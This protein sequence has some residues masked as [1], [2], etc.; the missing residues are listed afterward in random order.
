[1]GLKSICVV[2]HP[3]L[4][5][6]CFLLLVHESLLPAGCEQEMQINSMYNQVVKGQEKISRLINRCTS[7][8][9][10]GFIN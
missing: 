6:T 9:Q 4:D 10:K 1:M 2:T 7:I 8:N 5:T 3:I